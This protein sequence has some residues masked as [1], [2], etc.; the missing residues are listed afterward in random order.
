MNIDYDKI[1]SILN[2]NGFYFEKR[3]GQNFL[4]DEKLLNELVE[5]AGVTASDTVIEIGVGA[6]TLTAALVKKAKRVIGYEIDKKLQPV[7]KETLA[8]YKNAEI[9]FKDIMKEPM[10]E[11]ESRAGGRF[12][13]VANLPYY[14]TTPVLM[15][16]IEESKAVDKIAVTV[17]EEVADRLCAKPATAD[18]G[19]I[20]VAIN[21]VGSAEKV[22]RIDRSRFMPAPNVDS[23]VAVINIDRDKYPDLDY[24]AF[25]EVVK[26]AFS[27]RRKTLAN[28]L[29]RD[30]SL[31]REK[32][33]SAVFAVKG[34]IKARG[35]TLTAEEFIRLYKLL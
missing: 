15:R 2:K 21:A 25:R 14:I 9:V 19:A 23:A 34:D 28:N 12:S 33:E 22:M 3:Y 5:K 16:F 29:M 6:G 32:A 20:T 7:L 17:Q 8:D 30:F 31:S 13:V 18:Y 11:I 10:S 4:T 24:K 35:E 1:K 27:S 26:S